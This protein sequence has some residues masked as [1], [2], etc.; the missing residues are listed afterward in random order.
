MNL[1]I[2]TSIIRNQLRKI[3]QHIQS[4]QNKEVTSSEERTAARVSIEAPIQFQTTKMD[5]Q[6]EIIQE[7]ASSSANLLRQSE[8]ESQITSSQKYFCVRSIP[9]K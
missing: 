2:D 5:I 7:T 1:K 4:K 8:D 3:K 9:G 6:N